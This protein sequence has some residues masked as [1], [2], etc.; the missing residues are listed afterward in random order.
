MD[1]SGSHL[2]W[3][4]CKQAEWTSKALPSIPNVWLSL[5]TGVFRPLVQRE[6]GRSPARHH[7]HVLLSDIRRHCEC[8]PASVIKFASLSAADPVSRD[9]TRCSHSCRVAS[10]ASDTGPGSGFSKECRGAEREMGCHFAADQSHRRRQRRHRE[11]LP[12]PLEGHR[13]GQSRSHLCRLSSCDFSWLFEILS[14]SLHS[15]VVADLVTQM[16]LQRTNFEP[17]SLKN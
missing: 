14:C 16:C 12:I 8:S 2:P 11:V 10:A 1:A 7:V 5:R 13:N 3:P 15:C 4:T 9:G 17:V 6:P